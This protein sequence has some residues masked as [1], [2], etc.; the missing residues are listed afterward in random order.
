M[1]TKMVDGFIKVAAATPKIKVA[2]T[3]YNAQEITNMIL[4]A[5]SAGAK[6]I[7][8]PE[9]CI[10]GYT[11]SDLFLQD[12][13]LQE[14]KKELY[15]IAENTKD[16][17]ALV[18]VGLPIEREQKLYNAAAVIKSGKSSRSF[19]KKRYHPMRSFMRQGILRPE[20]VLCRA[21]QTAMMKFPLEQIFCLPVT[22]WK[23][24]SPRV[25][26]VKMCGQPTR[27]VHAMRLRAQM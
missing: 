22:M 25:K 20:M 4:E 3:A 18:F 19:Q 12:K 13:L 24:L 2:D 9:L 14:A 1:V 16:T 15:H 10:T 11:C 7:V 17:D 27:Q 23:D 21:R 6:I 26:F 8:L 5:D